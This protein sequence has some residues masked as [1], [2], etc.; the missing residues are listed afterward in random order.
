MKRAEEDWKRLKRIED[1][2]YDPD[3]R[4]LKKVEEDWKGLKRTD[5]Y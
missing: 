5:E 2:D 1:D 4:G 3:R